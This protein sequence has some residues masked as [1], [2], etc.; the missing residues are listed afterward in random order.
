MSHST[1]FKREEK[2]QEV[3]PLWRGIG[4]LTIV[5]VY[6]FS[7]IVAS[8]AIQAITDRERPMQFSGSAA[9]IPSAIRGL[10]SQMRSQFPWKL[11][12]LEASVQLGSVTVVD[13]EIR[14]GNFI[15]PGFAALVV[16]LFV[17]A[18]IA[19]GYGVVRGNVTDKRDARGW[20]PEKRVKKRNVR[21]C[22]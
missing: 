13:K 14:V 15:V 4:C 16:S 11:F 3:N 5:F 18:L 8:G 12:E 7:F 22:R 9:V 21:K 2:K 19:A 20:Q 6:I 10:Q 17:Y 1:A